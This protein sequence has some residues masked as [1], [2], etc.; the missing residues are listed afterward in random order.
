MARHRRLVVMT[1]D[2][3]MPFRHQSA[4]TLPMGIVSGITIYTVGGRV[5]RHRLRF[6]QIVSHLPFCFIPYLLV[7][8]IKDF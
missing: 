7:S 6:G 8:Q 4:A 3:E 2:K 5:V 1:E